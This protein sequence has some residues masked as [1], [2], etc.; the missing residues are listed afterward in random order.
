MRPTSHPGAKAEVFHSPL[1]SS[2]FGSLYLGLAPRSRGLHYRFDHGEFSMK[3]VAATDTAHRYVAITRLGRSGLAGFLSLVL[4]ACSTTP[5]ASQQRLTHS[6]FDVPTSRGGQPEMASCDQ[7]VIRDYSA[8]VRRMLQLLQ[9]L[10][11][12]SSP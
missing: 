11:K 9:E 3:T 12:H 1:L 7:L 2:R 5:P 4:T 6:S 8:N 10:E